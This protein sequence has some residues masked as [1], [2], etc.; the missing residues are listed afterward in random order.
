MR[1]PSFKRGMGWTPENCFPEEVMMKTC[2]PLVASQSPRLDALWV[3]CE[4]EETVRCF[5]Q[6]MAVLAP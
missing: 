6:T 4:E 5:V 3:G 2:I 1:G